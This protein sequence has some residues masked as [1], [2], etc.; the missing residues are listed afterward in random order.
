MINSVLQKIVWLSWVMIY[1]T[2]QTQYDELFGWLLG[3]TQF[4][5]QETELRWVESQGKSQPTPALTSWLTVRDN[6]HGNA[7]WSTE[8][9]H[10]FNLID[11]VWGQLKE[12]FTKITFSVDGFKMFYI[13][14]NVCDKHLCTVCIVQNAT[15]YFQNNINDKWPFQKDNFSHM[16]LKGPYLRIMAETNTL[17]ISQKIWVFV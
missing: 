14:I 15:L 2:K 5:L 7:A 17:C 16:I 12:L 11:N 6:L 8:S 1:I 4:H 3:L 10:W 9:K 13:Y